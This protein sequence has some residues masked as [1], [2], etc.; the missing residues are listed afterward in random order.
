MQISGPFARKTRAL[1]KSVP[2]NSSLGLRKNHKNKMA[3]QQALM[4]G[5][6]LHE[7]RPVTSC[8]YCGGSRIKRKGVRENKY[9]NVQ[10]YYCHPC[11]RKFTP[12]VSKHKSFPLRIIMDALILYNSLHGLEEAAATVSRKYGITISRQNVKNWVTGFKEYLP[13]LRMRPAIEKRYRPRDLLVETQL[14][15]GQVYAFKYHRAKTDLIIESGKVHSRFKPLQNFLA[16]VPRECPHQLFREQQ[17]R[18]ST[19]KSLFNLDQV[20]IAPKNN[21]AVKCARFVL[22]AV[23]TN[24]LRHERLQEFMLANDSVTVAVEVPIT[25]TEEDVTHFQRALGFHVPFTLPRGGV[26]TG[27]IDIVQIRNGMIHI[28]DFKPGAKKVK[29]IEQLTLYALALSRLTGLRLYHFKCAWF[30]DEDYFEFY[31]LHVVYKKRPKA[32]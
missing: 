5:P 3:T 32:A 30:D 6:S 31:P 1:P 7:T 17:G 2:N 15:H 21:A 19:H 28:L 27:H 12:L 20:V 13:I 24:K 26:I 22:Q 16:G 25:L 18:A 10:L 4:S 9:G 11:N 8:P 14:F 23:A 29:P